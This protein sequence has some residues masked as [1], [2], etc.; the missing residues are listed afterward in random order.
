MALSPAELSARA[1][2]FK[3]FRERRLELK[4]ELE[5]LEK[6]ERILKQEL[7]QHIQEAN[8]PGVMGKLANISLVAKTVP[9]VE[10]WGALDDYILATGDLSL[11]Q[12]RLGVKAVNERWEAGEDVPGVTT[13]TNY[14]LS[15]RK[16]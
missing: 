16:A 14:D 10:D 6:Q 5:D 13:E 12:R 1:D 11:L 2:A 4:R 7:I 3:S 9:I 15:V 8:V